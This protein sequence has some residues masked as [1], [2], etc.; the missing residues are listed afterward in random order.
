MLFILAKTN[1][2]R[3][4]TLV[5]TAVAVGIMS[6]LILVVMSLLYNMSST[7]NRNRAISEVDWEASSMISQITQSIRNASSITAPVA[8]ASASS[9]TLALTAVSA[10]NPTVYSTTSLAMYVSKANGTALRISSPNVNVKSLVF[11]NIT[12]SST[13]GAVRV[14]LSVAYNNPLNK[15]ELNYSTT[16][17]VTVSI[18]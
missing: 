6:V 10:E 12:A 9:L 3:G 13:D 7:E 15:P 8:G 5:E 16:R 1:M 2:K 17:Y 4:V 18:R 14:T 11:Q